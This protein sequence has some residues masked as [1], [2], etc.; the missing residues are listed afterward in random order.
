[1]KVIIECETCGAKNRVDLEK[2]KIAT[3][4]VCGDCK[5]SLEEDVVDA[6]AEE[7][8]TLG[9]EEAEEGGTHFDPAEDA[10]E[11]DEKDEEDEE[12]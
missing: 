9:T 1:M 5:D 7:A 2:A 4:T 8:E 12:Y 3:L 6:L 11:E 10:D